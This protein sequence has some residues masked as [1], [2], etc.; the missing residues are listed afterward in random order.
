MNKFYILALLSGISSKIYDDLDDNNLFYLFKQ[1]SNLIQ[2]C[3]K[4]FQVITLTIFSIY[5]Y[6]FSYYFYIVNIFNY[7]GNNKAF[8]KP[9]ENALLLIF[10]I[11]L[12]F[13]N[14]STFESIKYFDI[15]LCI[16]FLLGM[17]YE[18]IFITDEISNIKMYSR[19]S[20]TL[21]YIFLLILNYYFELSEWV[22]IIIFY[23]IGYLCVSSLFQYLSVYTKYFS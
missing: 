16:S 10:P 8:S 22:K 7:L 9:Y 19:I 2:E 4:M 13:T 1:N 11:I 5:Y 21:Y 18:P 20:L 23:N 17:F 15:Y 3:L 6:L 12:V 14:Y